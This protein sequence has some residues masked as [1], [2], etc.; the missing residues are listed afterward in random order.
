MTGAINPDTELPKFLEEL[1]YAGIDQVI[2]EK[3]KQLD[4]WL[5]SA[6]KKNSK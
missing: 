2:E 1:E 6:G 4:V 5:T 3:Q